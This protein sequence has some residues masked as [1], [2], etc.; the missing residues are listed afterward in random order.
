MVNRLEEEVAYRPWQP[1]SK[2][3]TSCFVSHMYI[4]HC[5]LLNKQLVLHQIL[6]HFMLNASLWQLINCF[7]LLGL[8]FS[9]YDHKSR[10]T[11]LESLGLNQNLFSYSQC[12]S[13]DKKDLW[14]CLRGSS[15]NFD[16]FD[17]QDGDLIQFITPS[18]LK[19]SSQTKGIRY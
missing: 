11:H 9:K 3:K 18:R 6:F 7:I 13:S 2:T 17:H 19:N 5:K 1:H 14:F 12:V 15:L 16:C 10:V 4:N 8:I